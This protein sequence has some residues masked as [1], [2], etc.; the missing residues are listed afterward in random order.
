MCVP[1][2]P[3]S[4]PRSASYI[5]NS[6]RPPPGTGQPIEI[7]QT[8]HEGHDERFRCCSSLYRGFLLMYRIHKEPHP[9][10]LRVDRRFQLGPTGHGVP[11]LGLPGRA[12]ILP[13]L[14]EKL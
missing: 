7:C 4:T 6:H 3:H 8:V 14:R 2:Q 13:T 5:D 11:L 1:E 10:L 9:Q 12:H